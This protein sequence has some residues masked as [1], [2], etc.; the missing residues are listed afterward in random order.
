MDLISYLNAMQLKVQ[1]EAQNGTKNNFK[2]HLRKMNC[3]IQ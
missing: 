1:P 2:V 3:I